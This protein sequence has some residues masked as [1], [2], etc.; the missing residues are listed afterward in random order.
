MSLGNLVPRGNNTG[1]LG[2]ISKRWATIYAQSLDVGDITGSLLGTSSYSEFSETSSLALNS[3]SASFADIS[4]SASY[5]D[6]SLTSSYATLALTASYA[7]SAS[8]EITKEVSS[9]YAET[10]SL[11]LNSISSSYSDLAQ[12]A[13]FVNLAQT[14]SYVETAQTASFV[15]LAQTASFVNLAQTASYVE[16]AQTASFT[17]TSLTASYS[18]N[19]ISSSYSDF[20]LTS[21]FANL[22][23]TASYIELAQTASYVESAQ[24]ASF[25]NLAQTAS[26]AENSISSSYSTFAL[27]ASY[28]ENAGG[29]TFPYT[30]SAIISGS[31]EV[32]GSTNISSYL[33]AAGITYPTTDGDNGDIIFTDGAGN[34]SFGR[35]TVFANVKNITSGTLQKGTPVHVTG[36]IGNANEVVPAS[37]SIALTMPAHFILNENITSGSEGKAIAVGFINGVNTSGFTEGDT[38]YVGADGGYTNIKPTG[39]NLIQNLGIVTKI[40]AS[41]GSG[42][43]L[44]AGRSNDVPN[45][46]EGYTWVGNSD[47]VATPIATSSI[48]NVVSSSYASTASYV[49]N[50]QTASFATTAQTASYVLGLNVNGPVADALDA[51]SSSYALTASYVE[52]AQ[53]ASYVD[54]I[55]GN[56]ITINQVGTTFEISGS[57]GGGGSLD[58]GSLLTTASAVS[59]VI[60]FTKGDSSTFDITVDTGSASSGLSDEI[61]AFIWFSTI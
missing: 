40:D 37:A 34:L 48:Q 20:T 41:N 25:V 33:T 60:T 56:N 21:S 5:S 17:I 11:A 29:D 59:N 3:I 23:Q 16:L 14:A 4:I 9:S 46:I 6:T 50:A 45:I 49:E 8:H 43:I 35:T 22:A 54:L 51:V 42:Y 39:S 2:T 47:G 10:A 18:E 53:T 27:T 32:T 55:A 19:A 30:G 58:T 57:A 28:A 26:Y 13:S 31:L 36:S 52:T 12:T 38:V 1:S 44:G 61:E 24:T 15:N 7:V